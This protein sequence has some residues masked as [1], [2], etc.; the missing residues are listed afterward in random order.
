MSKPQQA[1]LVAS[2]SIAMLHAVADYIYFD[3]KTIQSHIYVALMEICLQVAI[4]AIATSKTA[5]T[6]R[7][8][9]GR[10]IA[11]LSLANMLAASY[12]ALF[13]VSLAGT[14]IVSDFTAIFPFAS[15]AAYSLAPIG[16]AYSDAIANALYQCGM[17]VFG[18]YIPLNEPFIAYLFVAISFVA[19][20]FNQH[21]LWLT[22]EIIN[23]F[24]A[25]VLMKTAL[26]FFLS[27]Q[28]AWLLPVAYL[29]LFEVHGIAQQLFKDGIVAFALICLFHTYSRYVGKEKAGISFELLAIF[30]ITLLYN[31]R[32][33]T[34]AA[35]VCLSIL[36]CMFDRKR[37]LIHTRILLGGL[38]AIFLLGNVEGYANK[39]SA[40]RTR[41]TDKAIHGTAAHLDAQNLTYTTTKENSLFHKLKLHEV[42]PSNFFYAPVVKGA[43]YF[44]LP[45]PVN[46]YVNRADLF[47]KMS[48]TIYFI[49]FPLLLAGIVSILKNRTREELYLLAVFGLFVV[50]I[51]G[52]GPMLLPRYRIMASPFFLLIAVLGASRIPL[53]FAVFATGICISLLITLLLWYDDLYRMVQSIA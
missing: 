27:I 1:V 39:L 5:G 51:L 18:Q 20:E 21:I 31:L 13:V 41:T 44:L 3:L 22:L 17:C 53:R 10:S 36:N 40:S 8:H 9:V 30:L 34:L 32:S 19:G 46:H 50:L 12:K 25:V 23:F 35:I 43:L 37:W 45:L 7:A 26:K 6:T 2:V 14:P 16:D 48:T 47:H 11:I 4:Y 24:A 38:V 33:G 49:L 28:H 15:G 52:A 29:L 42:T